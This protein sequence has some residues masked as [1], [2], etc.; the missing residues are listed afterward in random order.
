MKEATFQTNFNRWLKYN[1][2]QTAKFELKICKEKSL[3]Y[4]VLKQHQRD[5]LKNEKVIFKIPDLGSQNPFDCFM[6]H[7]VPGYVVIQFYKHGE[8]KFY[9]INIKDFERYE[10]ASPSKSI[11]EPEANN[12]AIVVGELK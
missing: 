6:L 9:I 1:W 12:I 2:D 10:K 3:P 5:A 4:S 8:K 11:R 7:K